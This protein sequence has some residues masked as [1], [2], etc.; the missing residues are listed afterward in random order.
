MTL[1]K[2]NDLK[3][4]VWL[5]VPMSA[6]SYKLQPKI[7]QA[8]AIANKFLSK[9][10]IAGMVFVRFSMPNVI[11][12]MLSNRVNDDSNCYTGTPCGL[13]LSLFCTL[14]L[15]SIENSP[16]K[17]RSNLFVGIFHFINPKPWKLHS[18]LNSWQKSYLRF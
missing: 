2:T 5:I 16:L 11:H 3:R 18:F 9:N 6:F 10:T 1:I 15:H 7:P 12:L 17:F 4:L 14:H 8:N 13:M